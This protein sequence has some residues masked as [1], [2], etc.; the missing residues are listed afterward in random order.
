MRSDNMRTQG[1][2]S[3]RAWETWRWSP[4]NGWM[5]WRGSSWGQ[6]DAAARGMGGTRNLGWS[7]WARETYTKLWKRKEEEE[8]EEEEGGG[9]GG[10]GRGGRGGG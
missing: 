6:A 1:A 10:G 8:E 5:R 2:G 7:G 4:A 3:G 9:R